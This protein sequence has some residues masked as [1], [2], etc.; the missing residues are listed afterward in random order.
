[1]APTTDSRVSRV[2]PALLLLSRNVM[3]YLLFDI[4]SCLNDGLRLN[5]ADDNA[6]FQWIVLLRR[7][8]VH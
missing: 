1:M 4:L 2:K 7:R 8:L 5:F 3:Y 6:V